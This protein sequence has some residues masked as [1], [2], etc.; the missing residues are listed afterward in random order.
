MVPLLFWRDMRSLII[1]ILCFIIFY[2]DIQIALADERVVSSSAV[3][4]KVIFPTQIDSRVNRLQRFLEGYESPLAPYAFD[5]VWFADKYDIDWRLI[6][7]ISGV[8]ST[9]GKNIPKNSF[10]A[11]GW[12]NGEYFFNSWDESIEVVS[13]AL[14]EKYYNKGLKNIYSI[15]RRYAPPSKTWAWKVIFFMEKIDSTPVEFDF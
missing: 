11:Y 5:I 15:G 8:E 10:N 12:A 14:R 1:F 2:A 13:K 4:K 9:F 7:A 6:P 3:I